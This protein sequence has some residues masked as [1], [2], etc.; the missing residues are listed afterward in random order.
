MV[1]ARRALSL[2]GVRSPVLL[3]W[4]LVAS[5][6]APAQ[7]P[8]VNFEGRMIGRI[9]F[10]P[11]DQPLPRPELDAL[12]P[13]RAGSPLKAAEI[14]AGIQKLYQTGRFSD[15]SV[16][17][18]IEAA[19]GAVLLTFATK[20]NFFVSGATVEGVSEPPNTAQLNSATKLELGAKFAEND[21]QQATENIMERLRANG[22]Y[23]AKLM[24]SI[25][26][27]PPTEEVEVGF[28]VNPGVRAHFDG[29]TLEGNYDKPKDK[30]VAQTRW[31]QEL[32]PFDA[33]IPWLG[34]VWPF[35]RSG[36]RDVTEK[37]VQTG[38]NRVLQDFQRGNH[39]QARVTLEQ[40]VYH[41]ESNSVTPTL[42]ITIGPTI[43]VRTE[44]AK[45]SSG[46]LQE[47][48]PIYQERTVDRSLLEEG[49]RN[50]IEYFQSQGYFEADADF[51]EA[52]PSPDKVLIDYRV[53]LNRRHKLVT[54][55]LSGNRFFD[56][57]TL[58]DRLS[59]TPARVA[60]PRIRFG[61]YSQ[62]RLDQDVNTLLDLYRSNG[63]RE[64]AIMPQIQ[65][66]FRGRP[67][68]I[69]VAIAIDEGP[70]WTVSALEIL[71]PGEAEL[72][73]LRSL[74]QSTEG[75]G[76]SEA[77]VAADRDAILTYYDNNGY[78][79][80][81][82][83][84]TRMPGPT[85]TMV[86]L[87]YTVQPGRHQIVRGILYRGLNQ[88]KLS[89]VA[90]R[91][92]ISP[93]DP[94]SPSRMAQA[95]QKLYDLGIFS[96]VEMAVQNPDGE[97]DRKYLIL[98]VTEAEKYSVTTGVGAQLGRIGSGVTTFDSPAGTTGFSPRLSLGISRLNFM[99]LAHTISLQTR[100]STIEQ[101]AVLSYLAPQFFG[102][103][104]LALTISGVFDLARDIRTF[105]SRRWEGNFQVTQKLSRANQLQ[106]RFTFR[107]VS[108]SD[109][110]IS[111]GL[112]PIFS[113]PERVGQLSVSFAQDRRDDPVDTHRGF[114]NTADVG[115]SLNALGSQ[116]AFS[117]M[118]LRNSTYH[119]IGRSVVI[120]RTIQFGYIQ[121]ISGLPDIP[122]PERFFAGGA[123]S[124][125]SFPDNQAGPRDLETGFPLGGKALLLH[126]TELRFPLFGNNI[127]GVLFHDMGNVFDDLHNLNF[128][129]RQRNLQDFDYMVHGVGFGV[130]YRTPVGPLRADFSLSPNSPRFFGFQGTQE[131]LLTGQGTLKNQRIN[132]FQFHFSLG[133]TF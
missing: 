88:T 8:A 16:D 84:W 40:L 52:T 47:L 108:V 36:W 50:L 89:L 17:A 13:F 26:R 43:E 44:G 32:W 68:E 6:A 115:M 86:D 63:F 33:D 35:R 114:Y 28:L 113:V 41:Q 20:P 10:D 21:V 96:K 90:S 106:Y 67:G 23:Q 58:R 94:I 107:R 82:F 109:L 57:A 53:T 65:D 55:A 5:I 125:R 4:L 92:G 25:E 62:K 100:F 97:E 120:A 118:L 78:P 42:R 30:V 102:Q 48:V 110:V 51:E 64:V 75:Q 69:G 3:V 116:T 79:D 14:R 83:D 54:V 130:R 105:A 12:L 98:R 38:V 29:V 22:L 37:R 104:N 85:P 128:R 18:N 126:S 87:R 1:T 74:L 93:G 2:S 99:G 11:E 73:Y 72:P 31:R 27:R 46:R 124:N 80:A 123:S 66:D 127:G 56:R 9:V 70:Q 71:G 60:F 91:T 131:E 7:E 129:F 19:S 15:I 112:I 132:V 77:N 103:E 117:R 101:R 59:I 49:R 81:T 121:R 39:L 119:R 111:P 133:Q 76:F 24:P 34:R 61:K 45:V 122:L 95:Q